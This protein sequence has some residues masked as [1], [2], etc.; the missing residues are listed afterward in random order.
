VCFVTGA[1]N[2]AQTVKV[3]VQM[4]VPE[5]IPLAVFAATGVQRDLSR[6]PFSS[7]G[8]VEWKTHFYND[9]LVDQPPACAFNMGL[10]LLK[11]DGTVLGSAINGNSFAGPMMAGTIGLMLSADPDLLPWDVR[12]ILTATALDVG[13][14]GY[15]HETGHGLLNCFRAVKE[16]LRRKALR[17]G[18]DAKPYEGREKDDELDVKTLGKNLQRILSVATV[19]AGSQAARAGIKPGDILLRYDGTPITD[20]LSLMLAREK[21]DNALLKMVL[22][23]LLRDGKEMEVRVE[24]GPLGIVP[25]LGFRAPVFE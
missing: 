21:A 13:K 4:R 11:R 16:V 24:A 25:A 19:Q 22:V 12:G 8:P 14:K 20:Q 17:E 5:D 18:K 6:T 1:G 23:V 3:P 10:P 9:G 7:T 2:F 15:D